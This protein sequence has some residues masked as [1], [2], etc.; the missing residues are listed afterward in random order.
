MAFQDY[1]ALFGVT[2][3]ATADEIRSA[4]RRLVLQFHPDR[5]PNDPGAET[6]FKELSAAYQI[7]SDE[8]E[9]ARYDA[10]YASFMDAQRLRRQNETPPVSQ[11]EPQKQKDLPSTPSNRFSPTPRDF[12]GAGWETPLLRRQD[13]IWGMGFGFFFAVFLGTT[14]LPEFSQTPLSKRLAWPFLCVPMLWL[15]Q[16]IGLWLEEAGRNCWEDVA[17]PWARDAWPFLSPVFGAFSLWGTLSWYD[18]FEVR[19]AQVGV[20]PAAFGGAVASWCGAS[21]GRAFLSTSCAWL[22]KR[23]GEIAAIATALLIAALISPLLVLIFY[24]LWFPRQIFD[25]LFVA[26]LGGSAGGALASF[27]GAHRFPEPSS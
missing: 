1:Y 21:I 12:F 24:G 19:L 18:F 9:R 2:P 3:K 6:T 26:T 5:N 16:E 27:F 10:R 20:L 17:P 8:K 25:A 7:L 13:L 23:V 11:R 14:Y 15:S 4:Y 22:A